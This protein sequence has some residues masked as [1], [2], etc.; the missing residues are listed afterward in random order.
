MEFLTGTTDSFS[1][2]DLSIN[3]S[4]AGYEDNASQK[5]LHYLRAEGLLYSGIKTH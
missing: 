3:G 2:G 1:L 5:A 4:A